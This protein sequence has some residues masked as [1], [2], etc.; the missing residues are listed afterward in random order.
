MSTD[1]CAINGKIALVTGAGRG[2]GRRVALHLAEHGAGGVAVNDAS[3]ER[4][5]AVAKEVEAAG[6]RALAVTADV[7]DFD[8]VTAMFDQV[9][10][11]LGPVGILVNNAGNR[12]V[13][14]RPESRPRP[15]WEQTPRTGTRG[16]TS[17]S[18]GCSTARATRWRRWSPPGSAGSSP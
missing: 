5:E 15:F 10:A 18:T 9:A 14:P 2:V 8:A 4:A 3:A 7:G 1:I 12:G 17:T 6:V 13:A 11:E 16:S